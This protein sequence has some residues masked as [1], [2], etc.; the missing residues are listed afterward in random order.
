MSELQPLLPADWRLPEE[1]AFLADMREAVQGE[2]YPGYPPQAGRLYIPASELLYT[3]DG[4]PIFPADPQAAYTVFD[5]SVDPSKPRPADAFHDSG[6]P[7]P[8]DEASKIFWDD[9]QR[10]SRGLPLHRHAIAMV[11]D[12]C[13]RAIIGPGY[14]HHPGKKLTVDLGIVAPGLPAE[15]GKNESNVTPAKQISPEGVATDGLYL[16]ILTVRRR[17]TKQLALPG[18]N[19]DKGETAYAAALRE[20]REETGLSFE[21]ADSLGK[22]IVADPRLTTSIETETELFVLDAAT[23]PNE[24]PAGD[25]EVVA[26]E[27]L[28]A[29]SNL[30]VPRR[31]FGSHRRMLLEIVDWYQNRH[32]VTIME[33]GRILIN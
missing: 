25:E 8:P 26:S 13:I 5:H 1:I 18:G 12:P 33:N 32:N 22:R 27:W 21:S 11:T 17:D 10:D 4:R 3:P 29:D 7:L 24:K 9:M 19:I 6:G 31:F 15:G 20:T 14:Y 28:I 30:L 16:C 2:P 23:I